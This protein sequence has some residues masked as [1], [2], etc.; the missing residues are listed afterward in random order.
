MNPCFISALDWTLQPTRSLDEMSCE[1]LDQLGLVG[2]WNDENHG[3]VCHIMWYRCFRGGLV[4]QRL[5]LQNAEWN[6]NCVGP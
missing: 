2:G 5:Q 6:V 1:A 4:A 3:P